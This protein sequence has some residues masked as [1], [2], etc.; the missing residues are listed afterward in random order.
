MKD[1]LVRNIPLLL[2]DAVKQFG[3]RPA[4]AT[5]RGSGEFESVS[6]RSMYE[7]GC[8]VATAL[9]DL[10]IP[11]RS[12]I[13][14]LADN[15]REWMLASYGIQLAG[16][17]DVPRGSDVTDGDITYILPHSDARAVFV[18]NVKL[19]AQVQRLKTQLPN[20]EHLFLLEGEPQASDGVLSIS[21]LIERGRRLREQGDRRVEERCESIS[22]DDLLTLIY[23]S[24]TTG[25]PKGVM[26][27]HENLLFQVRHCPVEFTPDDRMLSLLPIWHIAERAFETVA[28]AYG[29]CTYYSSVRRFRGDL[30]QVQPTFMLSAPRVWESVYQAIQDQLAKAPA[31][32]QRLFRA[33]FAC[34]VGVRGALRTLRRRKA[35]VEPISPIARSMQWIGALMKLAVYFVPHLILDRLVLRRIRNFFGPKFRSSVSG[36]GALPSYVDEFFDTLGI[37]VLEGYGMTE[38]SPLISVRTFERPVTGTVGPIFPK[39]EVRIVD[40]ESRDVIWPP[41]R[42]R[43]GEIHVRGSQ[44][45]RG[46]YKR[47]EATEKVLRDGWLNTGDLGMITFNDC[48]KIVGRSKDT[49][50]LLSGENVE[51]EPI[52]TC[53]QRSSLI[54]QC[55]VTGQDQKFLTAL[56]VPRAEVLARFG[57]DLPT[58]AQS[59]EVRQVIMDDIKMLIGANGGFKVFERVLDCRLLATEFSVGNEL[60]NLLKLK[61]HIIVE[62][63]QAEVASMYCE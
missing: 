56:I 4:F 5:R 11:L 32:R 55:M 15:R 17:V 38:T 57:N 61:R 24:G 13:A 19:L 43:K 54:H 63:Y 45:M 51:P 41:Q 23:T 8:C 28:I 30:Q 33:A 16:C 20:I 60:T 48:L 49:I 18:E 40:L 3:D 22:G 37:C 25:E 9:I 52:E 44:V 34:A 29:C 46:Y 47:P 36:G 50:V 42:G 53:L 21:S 2:A 27:T 6:F 58:L 1:I 14:V 39:T 62:K 7:Q 26:L 10:G 12:H 59:A 35:E 31:T